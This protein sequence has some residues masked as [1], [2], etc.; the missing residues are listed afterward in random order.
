MDDAAD[1]LDRFIIGVLVDHIGDIDNLK[2]A[3]AIL[4]L[5]VFD[6]ELSLASIARSAADVIASCDELLNNVVTD[7]SRCASH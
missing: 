1:A 3:F 7:V 5:N 4:L 2:V 6:E